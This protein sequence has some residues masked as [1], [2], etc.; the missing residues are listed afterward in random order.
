MELNAERH[1]LIDN[2]MVED[3]W[4]LHRAVVRPAKRIENPLVVP[5]RPWES[6]GVSAVYVLFDEQEN[7]F[8]MWYNVFSYI[9]WRNEEENWYTYWICYAESPDGITW[10]K[11]ELGIVE[12]EGSTK[13]NILMQGEWWATL[14]TVL[15]EDHE[16]D[17]AKKYKLLYTDVFGVSRDQVARDGGI[18]GDWP[19]RSGVCMAYSADGIHWQPYSGNPVIQGESDTSNI[20]FWDERIEKYVLYMRPPIYAGRWKR[21]IARAESKDLLQWSDPETVLIPDELDPLELYGMPVFQYQGY[22]FGLLQ[23]YHSDTTATIDVQLAFSRDGKNWERLPQRDVFLGLG[24]R[25]GQGIDFDSGMVF[26]GKPVFVG[27]EI[28][29]Y[30]SGCNRS[31]NDNGR[32]CIGLAISRIDR[33]IGRAT[34]PG[35]LGVLLTRPFTCQGDELTINT[36]S[37]DGAI[38]VEVL[39]EDGEIIAGYERTSNPIFSGDSLGH[40]VRWQADRN[41]SDLRGQ[42]I[43]LKFYMSNAVLYAFQVNR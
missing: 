7:L 35:E 36:T 9:A 1:L 25:H 14:G 3:A 37:T 20:V 40:E 19:G 29:F 23:V 11:P 2:Y 5:D 8:K 17:P 34:K 32:T 16:T 31:H 42:R 13:N 27:D 26:V 4:N 30:Y 39:T 24:V 22:Y 6:N 28:W 41:L 21:R 10:H 15:K 18:D 43:R 38:G 12:F 33:L